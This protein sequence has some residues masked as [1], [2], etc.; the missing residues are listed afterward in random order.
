MRRV[1]FVILIA[2]ALFAPAIDAQQPP[3]ARI[4]DRTGGVQ[5]TD[6]FVPFY[7]DP[8][9]GRVLIEIPAFGEDIL[10]YVSAASGAGS[11][12]LPFDRGI[13]ANGVIRFERSGP[14]VLVVLQN[15][16]YRAVGGTPRASRERPRLVRLVRAGRAARR[17]R[18]ERPRPCRCHAA[19][20]ARC[21]ER[22]RPFAFRQPGRISF[23]HCAQRVLP[24]AHEGVPA[25][26]RDR[27]HRHLCRRQS[28]Q[29]HQQ[30]HARSARVHAAHPPFV[31]EGARR[32]SAASSR[33]AHRRRRREFP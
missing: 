3:A 2:T 20:H 6:G 4:A 25:E 7:W 21:R 10:Y 14:R 27:N 31:P 8:A 5:R 12:E 30:R 24:G 15:L 17:G 26:H 16:D 11:V 32:V 1:T 9:R 13:L 33:S 18:R 22:G 19:V 23:R 28:R 29:S